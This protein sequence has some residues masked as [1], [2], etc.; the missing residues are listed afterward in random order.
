MRSGGAIKW[1][2]SKLIRQYESNIYQPCSGSQ[3]TC[4][5]GFSIGNFI[6]IFVLS[7]RR[8]ICSVGLWKHRENSQ[9][10]RNS[11]PTSSA[12]HV[13]V[14]VG[15][16][17]RRNKRISKPH[18][19]PLPS[20][21]LFFLHLAWTRVVL[22][23]DWDTCETITELSHQTTNT[24]TRTHPSGPVQKQ[25]EYVQ[26]GNFTHALKQQ[27]EQRGRYTLS[28]HSFPKRTAPPASRCNYLEEISL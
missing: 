6:S 27:P 26:I 14:D 7:K 25:L 11:S 22:L 3:L 13:F 15:V 10:T 28:S 5:L 21:L 16:N 4:F 17:C 23:T 20:P 18:C 12:H 9:I 1:K 8:G 2:I 19:L 24:H